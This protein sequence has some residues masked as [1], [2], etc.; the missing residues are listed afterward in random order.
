MKNMKTVLAIL[1]VG[2]AA[3]IVACGGTRSGSGNIDSSLVSVVEKINAELSKDN[4]KPNQESVASLLFE[5]GKLIYAFQSNKDDIPANE[6]K[7]GLDFIEQSPSWV[8]LSWKQIANVDGEVVTDE[9]F[10]KLKEKNVAVFCRFLDK[11]GNVL[12]EVELNLDLE[13]LA[14]TEAVQKRNREEREAIE[15]RW[16]EERRVR[17]A[18]IEKGIFTD[19]RENHIYRTGKILEQT[20]IADDLVLGTDSVFRCDTVKGTD[21]YHCDRESWFYEPPAGRLYT[22]EESKSVCPDGWR[23]PTI[24]ELNNDRFKKF[25]HDSHYMPEFSSKFKKVAYWSSSTKE[26]AGNKYVGAFLCDPVKEEGSWGY[27][28]TTNAIHVPMDKANS[29]E[30][31]KYVRCIK[32]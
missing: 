19:P 23:L 32:K 20:W 14:K 13:L 28:M 31:K 3:M 30:E 4:G 24:E 7:M 16:A 11:K 1:Y 17:E 18:P 22:W 15:K 12:G 9:F 21:D 29:L 2:L 26:D 5:D 10:A 8:F 27:H 25:A 6:V